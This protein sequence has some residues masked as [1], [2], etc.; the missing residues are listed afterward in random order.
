MGHSAQCHFFWFQNDSILNAVKNPKLF[1]M[2][3]MR[4]FS[5]QSRAGR[6]GSGQKSVDTGHCEERDARRGNLCKTRNAPFY[7]EIAAS[8]ASR[9]PRN[10]KPSLCFTL[11]VRSRHEKMLAL[12]PKIV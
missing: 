5:L 8:D 9:P 6:E 2:C 7:I 11:F 10:D 3:N 12:F 1:R 4:V